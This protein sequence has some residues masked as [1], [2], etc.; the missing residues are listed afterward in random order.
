MIRD[1]GGIVRIYYS[2]GDAVVRMATAKE[3]DLL[4]LCTE[5]R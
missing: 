3:S 2:A 4:A 5:K 1:D